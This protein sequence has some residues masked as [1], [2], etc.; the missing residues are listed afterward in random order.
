[1]G[2]DTDNPHHSENSLVRFVLIV[3]I[4]ISLVGLNVGN[5]LLF[6]AKSADNTD[7]DHPH[8]YP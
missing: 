4:G 3:K 1:M 7:Y 5:F 8:T 2:I 6:Q